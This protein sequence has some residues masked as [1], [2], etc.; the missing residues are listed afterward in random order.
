[1]DYGISHSRIQFRLMIFTLYRCRCLSQ[2][3]SPWCENRPAFRLLRRIWYA[4]SDAF[5]DTPFQALQNIIIEV[6]VAFTEL[7]EP[8]YQIDNFF[9]AI[10]AFRMRPMRA[11]LAAL[12]SHLLQTLLLI[13]HSSLFHNISTG[14]GRCRWW[15]F[16]DTDSRWISGR[17]VLSLSSVEGISGIVILPL[18]HAFHYTAMMAL[19][20]DSRR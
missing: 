9:R 1:M 12:S 19:A 20:F 5:T 13:F 16:F 17:R 4:D 6:I 3:I 10:S 11:A 14:Q 7:A 15:I 8:A 18:F 2:S